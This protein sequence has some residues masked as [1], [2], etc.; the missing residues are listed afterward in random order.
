MKSPLAILGL[1]PGR[2]PLF[3]AVSRGAGH[4]TR[5]NRTHN[6][7]GPQRRGSK[8]QSN[9]GCFLQKVTNYPDRFHRQK[10]KD[11]EKFSV[12]WR[13]GTGMARKGHFHGTGLWGRS[14]S[15]R[16]KLRER[17]GFVDVMNYGGGGPPLLLSGTRSVKNISGQEGQRVEPSDIVMSG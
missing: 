5:G 4:R 15:N 6:S 13:G 14:V 3:V 9:E 16:P 1:G 17:T 7:T 10:K 2:H 11:S 12:D 8:K